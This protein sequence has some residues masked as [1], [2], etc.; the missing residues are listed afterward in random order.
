V[1]FLIVLQ[2]DETLSSPLI[3][4]FTHTILDWVSMKTNKVPIVNI[5][6]LQVALGE[7]YLT[8]PQSLFSLNAPDSSWIDI[9]FFHASNFSHTNL[10][11]SHRKCEFSHRTLQTLCAQRAGEPNPLPV[12]YRYHSDAHSTKKALHSGSQIL[13]RIVTQLT[14][15]RNII[16]VARREYIFSTL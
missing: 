3:P 14:L 9:L 12:T 10:I 1:F 4:P 2:L 6:G 5:F 8:L 13:K 11:F 15:A 7:R 16:H